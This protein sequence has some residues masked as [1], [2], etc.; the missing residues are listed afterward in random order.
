MAG[1]YQ[2]SEAPNSE[3]LGNSPWTRRQGQRSS[4][5]V[6][7]LFFAV[8]S[9]GP[10]CD[11]VESPKEKEVAQTRIFATL[12]LRERSR[13]DCAGRAAGLRHVIATLTPKISCIV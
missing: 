6:E 11:H 5:V 13:T 9:Q 10:S 3:Q 7:D 12:L 8:A 4:G 1:W 2:T